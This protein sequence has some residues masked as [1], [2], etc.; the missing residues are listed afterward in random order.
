MNRRLNWTLFLA[1]LML[2]AVQTAEAFQNG[3]PSLDCMSCHTTIGKQSAM[4]EIKGIPDK[5]QPGQV[6]QIRVS[7]LS[8]TQSLGDVKGGFVVQASGGALLVTD[9]MNTQLSGGMLTHTIEGATR[10]SWTM[11]WQSPQVSGAVEFLVA[12]VAANGDYAA[13]GDPVAV[14]ML[15]SVSAR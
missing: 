11:A 12:A 10:R 5:F 8:E 2:G 6:Y 3:A 7:V 14:D 4:L 13:I 15:T 1:L 9:E